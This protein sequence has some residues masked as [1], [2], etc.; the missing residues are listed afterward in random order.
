MKNLPQIFPTTTVNICDMH[1]SNRCFWVSLDMLGQ[2]NFWSKLCLR[3]PNFILSRLSF[4]QKGRSKVVGT[5]RKLG[6]WGQKPSKVLARQLKLMTFSRN[7]GIRLVF[8]KGHHYG[9]FF[10]LRPIECSKTP[11][12]ERNISQHDIIQRK[13]ITT[14]KWFF[15][16]HKLDWDMEEI[17][18]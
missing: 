7:W 9:Q 6:G 3:A 15:L 11:Y 2:I 17:N 10:L 14:E 16:Y 13:Q 5:F 1:K 4:T 12:C 18:R 8:L